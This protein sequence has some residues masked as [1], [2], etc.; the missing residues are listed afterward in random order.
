MI[1]VHTPSNET[2]CP[3]VPLEVTQGDRHRIMSV[4]SLP[5]CTGLVC[6]IQ[7]DARGEYHRTTDLCSS[8]FNVK[9]DK[10]R[11]MKGE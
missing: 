1:K 2:N 7:T 6:S 9:E 5:R 3:H 4:V 10:E 11:L 8:G